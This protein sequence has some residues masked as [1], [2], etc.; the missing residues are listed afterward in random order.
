MESGGDSVGGAVRKPPSR[1]VIEAVAAAEDIPT[2]DLRPP[3][4]EP[5]HT[6]IDPESLDTLF[7]QQADGTPRIGGSVSFQY[8]GYHVVV[9]A[10][11]RVVLDPDDHE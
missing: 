10:D 5:L 9:M 3:E 2:T 8:C 6:A 7:S 11:G 4:Y 1:A